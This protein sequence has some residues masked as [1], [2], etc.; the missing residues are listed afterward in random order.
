MHSLSV[1]KKDIVII[2]FK[3]HLLTH[4]SNCRIYN[5]LCPLCLIAL[6]TMRE[7]AETEMNSGQTGGG[8]RLRE[9]V[10]A[11]LMVDCQ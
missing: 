7:G 6:N 11:A 4:S 9:L 5:G 3:L 10:V 8:L 1:K 2:L